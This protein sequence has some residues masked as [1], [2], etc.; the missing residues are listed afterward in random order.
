MGKGWGKKCSKEAILDPCYF[1]SKIKK[2]KKGGGKT[3]FKEKR[4]NLTALQ[5]TSM[6]M[7]EGRGGGERMT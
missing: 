3:Q 6:A 2:I 7:W 5:M 1:H 4:I